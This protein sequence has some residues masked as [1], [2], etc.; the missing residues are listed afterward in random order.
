VT[1]YTFGAVALVLATVTAVFL[2][3]YETGRRGRAAARPP[4]A[5]W[6]PC[7]PFQGAQDAAFRLP[8][9]GAVVEEQ[10]YSTVAFLAA[11]EQTAEIAA[12]WTRAEIGRARR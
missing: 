11:A 5:A 8:R 7:A 9:G 6:A 2:L 12:L 10:S 1:A 3:G 4:L